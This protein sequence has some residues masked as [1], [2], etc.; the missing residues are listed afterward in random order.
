MWLCVCL[1][2]RLQTIEYIVGAEKDQPCIMPAAC[3]GYI[4]GNL[5][6]HFLSYFRLFKNY[7]RTS[8]CCTVN[9]DIGLKLFELSFYLPV[10]KE[11]AA[12]QTLSSSRGEKAAHFPRPIG[13]LF[14]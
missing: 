6:V 1:V 5:Y 8:L 11:I 3:L 7:V 14:H 2:W 12:H 13:E 10:M 9:H 4:A